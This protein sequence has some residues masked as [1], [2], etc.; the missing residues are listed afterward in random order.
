MIVTNGPTCLNTIELRQALKSVR[1]QVPQALLLRPGCYA[2]LPDYV[3][4]LLFP[5]ILSV[6]NTRGPAAES[7]PA[8]AGS[9]YTM[10]SVYR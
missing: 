10:I 8:R 6:I 7:T 1:I 4:S 2:T 5:E 3:K 9:R